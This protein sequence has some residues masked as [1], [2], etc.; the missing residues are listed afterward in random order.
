MFLDA[1]YVITVSRMSTDNAVRPIHPLTFPTIK[2]NGG[3]LF[4]PLRTYRLS[5]HGLKNHILN[6]YWPTWLR[7]LEVQAIP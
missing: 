7:I 5:L 1:S 2:W 6:V 3:S 4:I